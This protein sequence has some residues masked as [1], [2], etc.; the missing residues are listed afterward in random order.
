MAIIQT[1]NHSS[2]W[3]A[4]NMEVF[5]VEHC[6]SVLFGSDGRIYNLD[7]FN[8][9]LNFEEI[10]LK[11]VSNNIIKMLI[12]E[13]N[14]NNYIIMD[15][16]FSILQQWGDDEFFLHETLFY[17]YD[18]HKGIIFSLLLNEGK[19]REVEISYKDIEKSYEKILNYYNRKPTHAI[20]RR[21]SFYI[22]TRVSLKNTYS[23]DN[24]IFNMLQKLK[25][26]I[27]GSLVLRNIFDNSG[28]DFIFDSYY[29]G[30]ACLLGMKKALENNFND[31]IGNFHE[32]L[33][34]I[35]KEF[36]K[37]LEHRNI[38]FNS[39]EWV[40]INLQT[41]NEDLIEAKNEYYV[42]YKEMKKIWALVT[43]AGITNDID[44]VV[45]VENY[46]LKLYFKERETLEKFEKTAYYIYSENKRYLVQES[47]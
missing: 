18:D 43:K 39:M 19:F 24:C 7:N 44:I 40:I 35:A 3:L 29:T 11:A 13:I 20:D 25:R 15:C 33:K 32:K 17:G 26:E 37:L 12:N 41:D 28:N 27:D 34:G 9:I 16:D 45:R 1:S 31:Q 36:R 21:N 42:C 30:T 22:I 2:A 23:E 6:I 38:I 4:A 8:D 47:K 14:K 46:L 5:F 10:D